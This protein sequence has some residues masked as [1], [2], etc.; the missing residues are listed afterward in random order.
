VCRRSIIDI[1]LPEAMTFTAGLAALY[2]KVL[3]L[4]GKSGS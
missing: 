3:E 4:G 2:L 1:R